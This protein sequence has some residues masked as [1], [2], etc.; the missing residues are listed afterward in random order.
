MPAFLPSLDELE[1][2]A[3]TVIDTK[4]LIAESQTLIVSSRALTDTIAA[5][6]AAAFDANPNLS[7]NRPIRP[8]CSSWLHLR[9]TFPAIA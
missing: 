4:A 1:R 7:Y 2:F 8:R 5:A 6:H 3:Q 9:T